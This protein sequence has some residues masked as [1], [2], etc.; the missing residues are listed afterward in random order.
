MNESIDLWT[1]SSIF[2]GGFEFLKKF[3]QFFFLSNLLSLTVGSFC[4]H[5]WSLEII[6]QLAFPRLPW[7]HSQSIGNL[8]RIYYHGIKN[9]SECQFN[10]KNRYYELLFWLR[11]TKQILFVYLPKCFL[12]TSCI[13]KGFRWPFSSCF[14]QLRI[15]NSISELNPLWWYEN[16]GHI[17]WKETA[18]W[19][20]HSLSVSN[21]YKLTSSASMNHRNT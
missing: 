11:S 9:D 21:Y 12:W 16:R 19:F 3:F 1:V 7:K 14:L 20:T 15:C 5:D 17:I 4:I 2:F 13:S 10:T 6:Q 8:D 18:L